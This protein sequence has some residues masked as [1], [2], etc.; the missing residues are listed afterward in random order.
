MRDANGEALAYAYC[1]EAAVKLLKKMKR[2]GLRRISPSCRSYF[3]S[4]SLGPVWRLNM[5][6]AFAFFSTDAVRA[7]ADT[8]YS[9]RRTHQFR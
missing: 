5:E 3:V 1:E 7:E 8:Y 2:G 6:G 9:G 4:R